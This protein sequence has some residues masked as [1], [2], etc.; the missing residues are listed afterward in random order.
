MDLSQWL[1]D[2]IDD[3][4][5]RLHT[6]VLELVPPSRQRE[7]P[8][9]GS[10]ILWNTFH[11]ARHASLALAVLSPQSWPERP[12]WL[13]DLISKAGSGIG[14]EEAASPW[15]DELSA[16]KVDAYV[17]D[18]LAGARRFLA[19]PATDLDAVPDASG[20]LIRA[21]IAP[22]EFGWL[23]RMWQDKPAAWLVRWPLTGHIGSHVGE[24]IATRNRMG[25]S[26]F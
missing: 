11:A 23:H 5:T 4:T 25:L 22:G 9:G 3:I 17:A 18:V 16:E 1:V 20:A 14:V 13:D 19:G 6:Q 7:R 12:D 24:M 10:A 15:A 21:G 26:P 2:E 8:G